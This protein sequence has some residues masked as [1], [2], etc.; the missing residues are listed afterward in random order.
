MRE[1]NEIIQDILT[2]H[3]TH[4]FLA[5]LLMLMAVYQLRY[6]GFQW[7]KILYNTYKG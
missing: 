6:C 5:F 4:F 2:E 1:R 7:I 3:H